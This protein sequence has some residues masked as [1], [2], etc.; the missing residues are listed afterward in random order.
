MS[1]Q[2]ALE[3][4]QARLLALA[5]LLPLE[6]VSAEAALGRFL[7]E[8]LHAARTQ[9]A[10]DLSAMD[11]YALTPGAGPWRVAGESRA[12]APY[13]AAMAAGEAVRISTGAIVPQGADRVLLQE[14]AAR[15]GETV[16]ATELPPP[17]RHI[18]LRGFDFHAGDLLLTC[19]ARITPGRMALALAAGQGTLTVTRRVRVAVMDSG[20][21]LSSDPAACLPHQIPASNAAMIAAMLAQLGRAV[22]RLGP[23]PD[24]RAALAAALAEA[25]GADILVTSGGA[26]VGDHDLIKPALAEWGA[27]TVFWRVA[28]KPGKPLLVATRQ[29]PGGSQVVLG[30][31]GNPVSSFVTAFL[32]ACPLV[33]TAMGDPDPLPQADTGIAGEDLP[34]I[35]P[36]REFLRAVRARGGAV[37]L[38]GSQDSSALSALA[39]ADCLIDRPAHAPAVRAGET[40]RLFHLQNG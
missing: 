8:D 34:A 3:D 2:L 18:R 13:P 38:A 32:F 20:D 28:I 5:P 27:Q 39:A 1:E 21:E 17:G 16:S 24:D 30:L 19:G 23:A 29:S 10:A 11:G 9:P 33:R 4:A 40:I 12:G 7:A 36:R 15:A 37:R 6:T 14:D 25:E 26:S 22:P 31:P 35:G